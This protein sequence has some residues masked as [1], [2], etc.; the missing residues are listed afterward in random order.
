MTC[1]V[2]IKTINLSN[3]KS[4]VSLLF[5]KRKENGFPFFSFVKV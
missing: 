1:T 4:F 5:G 3:E 2:H